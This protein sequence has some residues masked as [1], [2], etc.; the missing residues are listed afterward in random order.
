[1]VKG[2]PM[3]IHKNKKMDLLVEKLVKYTHYAFAQDSELKL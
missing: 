3:K 1:M 2:L